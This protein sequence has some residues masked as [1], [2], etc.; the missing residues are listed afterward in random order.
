M[1]NK[2][3]DPQPW[4]K[5]EWSSGQVMEAL[6]T[7]RTHSDEEARAAISWYYQKKQ[8]KNRWSRF[9][10]FSAIS[11]T[12]LGGLVPLVAAAGFPLLGRGN[13]PAYINQLGY[14]FFGLAA[15]CVAFD[16]YFGFSTNWMRYIGAATRIETARSQFLFEWQQLVA[17][18]LG[19][20]PEKE[21]L[22][23]ILQSLQKFNL[24][25]RE[26]V[27][28]ETGAWITEFQTNLSQL[29]KET[30]ALFESAQKDRAALELKVKARGAGVGGG[31]GS[32]D[33][34]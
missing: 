6:H 25:I 15:G 5:I 29:D 9:L 26:A 23:A 14:I 24:A 31:S 19:K 32:D 13:Q 10:R 7:L 27:E 2:N 18:L 1:S 30:R 28:Q 34:K 17:A 4:K 12:I 8:S 16:R 11:F 33:T 22:Q 20:E 3:I 21:Q